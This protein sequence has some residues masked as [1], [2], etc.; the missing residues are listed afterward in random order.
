MKPEE[1][2]KLIAQACATL[3]GSTDLLVLPE[4]FNTG[5]VMTPQNIPHHWQQ[6]T[7]L[8][9]EKLAKEFDIALCG[10]IPYYKE[11]EWYNTM[12]CVTQDGLSATYDKIHL[13]SLASENVEYTA[14]Q[15]TT[16]LLH[17]DWKIR[18]LICY[19]L[20]FPYLNFG[21]D[22][23][24]DIIIYSANWPIARVSHWES[25][26]IARAIENQCY[27]IGVNR[28][29]SDMN[30]FEYPGHSMM[31][32]YTGDVM[33]KMG[34]EPGFCTITLNKAGME[35]YRKKLPFSK[36]RLNVRYDQ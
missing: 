5:Y 11:K 14:G 10:S 19:D 21:T 1:N 31:V 17:R 27:V 16:S 34:D 35:E 8:A 22:S 36:D 26:L 25:L 13:F 2:L 32:D 18:P 15:T 24:P 23:Q 4:M 29:G 6:E 12:L 3:A 9:L 28:T 30:N 33:A 20:R 7:I